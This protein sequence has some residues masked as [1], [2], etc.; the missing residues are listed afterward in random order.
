MKPNK[1]EQFD[2]IYKNLEIP[3]AFTDKIKIYLRK[4]QTHSLHKTKRIN[5]P[6]RQIVTNFPGQILQSDLI[7]MQKFSNTNGGY[8]FILVVIDCFSKFLWCQALKNKTGKETADKLKTIFANMKYPVQSLIFDQGLEYVNQYVKSLLDER[9]IHW[10]H[11]MSKHKASSAERVNKTVKQ[12]IW[13]NFT[14]FNNKKWAVKLDEIVD[15]YNSTYHSTIKMP[16]KN[17]TWKNRKSIFKKMFPHIKDRINCRLKKNDQVRVALYKGIFEKG[18]T[19]NWSKDIFRIEKQFQRNK[20]CWY[21]LKDS[22]RH[23]Y[24]KGKYFY[25][26]QKI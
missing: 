5:F 3:G 26:L 1:Q 8:K 6:R 12:I 21:R 4:N 23:I 17:V 18:F 7:D 24:P 9:G 16:P 2:N 11:I 10:Y 14:E 25:Q 15:N 13:K 22:N 20:V 19:Q